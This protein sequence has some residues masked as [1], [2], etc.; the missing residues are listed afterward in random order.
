MNTDLECLSLMELL[1]LSQDVGHVDALAHLDGCHRCRALLAMLPKGVTLPELASP[2]PPPAGAS[3]RRPVRDVAI[4]TGTLW[5]AFGAS[6]DFAWV[7]A[8]VGRA[9]GP[10]GSIVVAPVIGEPE[11]ATDHDLRVDS[12]LLGYEAFVD[13]GNTG[14]VLNEQLVEPLARLDGQSARLLADLFRSIVSDRDRPVS[15]LV[16]LRVIDPADPRLLA[17][18]ERREALRTFWRRADSL[19]DAEDDSGDTNEDEPA[20]PAEDNESAGLAAV[21]SGFLYG[22]DAEWDRMTLLETSGADGLW[23]DCFLRDRLDLTDKRDVL[24]LARVLHALAIPWERAEP[25]VIGT[26]SRSPGGKR[27]AEGP[28]LPMA[29]RA[30]PGVS[31][32][33]VTEALYADQ[34]S[35]DSSNEA[36]A[37]EIVRYLAE[38]RHGLA[39]LQ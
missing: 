27:Q 31:E 13:V 4:K 37:H 21:L 35:I 8:V 25:A 30:Q 28:S 11:L 18:H 10:G 24:D 15:T 38:L 5:R 1:D 36:R 33:D 29:A 9:P 23:L 6:D 7:V 2:P 32:E 12:S 19:V 26:L 17:A 3:M 16:G 39:D 34:S 14:V 20:S 22:A